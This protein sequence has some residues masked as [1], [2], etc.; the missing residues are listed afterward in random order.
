MRPRISPRLLVPV[1]AAAAVVLATLA[2]PADAKVR[3]TSTPAWTPPVYLAGGGAEPSIR[4]PL[5]GS[6]NP[7][8]YV[9]APTGL[10]SNFWYVDEQVNADGTHTFHPSPP[11]QPDKGTGGGD[12]EISVANAVDP[13]TGCAAIAYSGLHNIDLLDNFTTA[14]SPDCGHSFSQANLYATQNTLTDRQWQTFDGAKTNFLIYHKVDTSQIV[15]SRSDDGGRTY[16]TLAPDGT[17]GIIDAAT[18]PAVANTN[19]VGNIVTDYAHPTG[20]NN[21][22]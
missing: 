15:V 10:G 22:L 11:Q 17:H 6:H 16:L 19:Q 1:A 9:S 14:S 18:F 13:S 2:A 3:A 8:A 4:N 12:S 7:A 21:L 20:A 5:V